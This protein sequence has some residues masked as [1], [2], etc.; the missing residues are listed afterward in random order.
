MDKLE[1]LRAYQMRSRVGL[2]IPPHSTG[3]GKA[4]PAALPTDEVRSILRRSGTPAVTPHTIDDPDEL[5]RHLAEIARRGH[6]VGNEEN[7]LSTRCVGATVHD[8]RDTPV[9]GISVSS[10]AF[11]SDERCV[12]VLAPLVVGVAGEISRAP[13]RR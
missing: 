9:G 11:E 5:L 8:Y 12:R 10:T 2:A 13:G 7:E 3:I 4:L 6:A 1:G